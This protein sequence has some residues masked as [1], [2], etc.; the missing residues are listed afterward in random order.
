MPDLVYTIVKKCLENSNCFAVISSDGITTNDFVISRSDGL[1]S[2]AALNVKHK[3][4]YMSL[5]KTF[6]IAKNLDHYQNKICQLV[7]SVPDSCEMKLKLQITRVII[8]AALIKLVNIIKTLTSDYTLQ[9]W[10]KY[11]DSILVN[12]SET[13]ISFSQKAPIDDITNENL[14]DVLS[15]LGINKSNLEKQILNLY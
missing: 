1:F 4:T 11:A 8:L 15:Y 5:G 12:A 7:P 9:E 3:K 2:P 10:N 13:L 14:V 6:S